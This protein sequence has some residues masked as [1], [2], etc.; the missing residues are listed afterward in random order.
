MFAGLV[1]PTDVAERLISFLEAHNAKHNWLSQWLADDIR[2]QAAAAT[3]RYAA[4]QALSVF[5]GVPYCVKDMLDAMPYET[6]Y[7]TEFMGKL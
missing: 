3:T 4:G 2:Q 6:S 7:G 1:T 5:D